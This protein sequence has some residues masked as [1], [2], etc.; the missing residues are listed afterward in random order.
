MTVEEVALEEEEANEMGL[1]DE[2]GLKR[3]FDEYVFYEDNDELGL[4][5]LFDVFYE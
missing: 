4:K 2:L 3:L 5:R 1:D